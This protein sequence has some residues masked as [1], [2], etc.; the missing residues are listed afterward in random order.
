M[1]QE[2]RAARASSVSVTPLASPLT[3]ALASWASSAAIADRICRVVLGYQDAAAERAI[4]TAVTGARGRAVDLAVTITR[5]TRE[6]RDVRMGSSVRGSIDLVL[7]LTGLAFAVRMATTIARGE[8][9]H[10]LL[11]D[12]LNHRVKNTL[13]ILQAIADHGVL[14]HRQHLAMQQA[15]A[16]EI[17]GIDL[18]LGFL[19]RLHK[20][21]VAI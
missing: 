13:A 9:L 5:A 15:V 18:D 19:P 6:H 7:L 10:N 2:R 12:E 4:T 3:L 1:S 11:I 14:R 17:E 20:A 8:A 16:G 21:D